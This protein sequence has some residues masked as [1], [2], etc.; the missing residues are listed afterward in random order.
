MAPR[1]EA[2]PPAL[3]AG[4]FSPGPPPLLLQGTTARTEARERR[5]RPFSAPFVLSHVRF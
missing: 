3:R 5:G 1:G 2:A 4:R